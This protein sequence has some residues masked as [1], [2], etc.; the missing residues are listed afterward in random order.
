MSENCHRKYKRNSRL[1]RHINLRY[2]KD[3]AVTFGKCNVVDLDSILHLL[4]EVQ[5]D[6]PSDECYHFVL[7]QSIR[8]YNFATA[9]L[10]LVMDI[11][12]LQYHYYKNF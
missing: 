6:I 5:G 2:P 7:R 4:K 8:G 3:E 9:N 10:Q 1:N 11:E 12:K